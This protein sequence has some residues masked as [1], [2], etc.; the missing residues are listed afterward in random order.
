MARYPPDLDR[1][2]R[3]ARIA[4]E[5]RELGAS[6]AVPGASRR[7]IA[8]RIE[9]RIREL[10]AEPAFPANLSRNVEAAHYTP[11]PDDEAT[12]VDGDVLK[13]DV[14]AHLDGAIS[15]TAKTV[16]VGGG[17]RHERLIRA[18][19]DALAAGIERVRPGGAIN[20]ISVAIE[21]A[22]RSLGFRPVENLMG[23]SIERY[24]LHAGVSIPNVSGMSDGHLEE[25]QIIAI[26]PF[27]TNGVGQIENG[28][29]GHIVRFRADPGTGDAEVA[30]LY[31]RVR[32]LPFTARY[33]DADGQAT[34]VRTKRKLQS[35][36][37][38]VEAG[39][40]LVS[41]AEHTVLVTATGA[42]VLTAPVAP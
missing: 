21:R 27:A 5:A 33:L 26:E 39:G 25:G 23:H 32:T 30:Q 41:Q 9:A 31:D 1:W 13:V 20:D 29:F 6:L 36:P 16:E 37:V 14:G 28:P 3:A 34:L 42:E 11:S 10:G 19:R 12:L 7:E 17:R 40:G 18:S 38:F 35:Y 8:D 4:S 15:D 22:I 2:R 24:L